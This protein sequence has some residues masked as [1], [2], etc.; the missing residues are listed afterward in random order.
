[1]L[2]PEVVN[3]G[4]DGPVI[5]VHKTWMSVRR[6]SERVTQPYIRCVSTTQAH[7]TVNVFTE[8]TTSQAVFVCTI[9]DVH[10]Y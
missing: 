9:S 3:A 7:L 10:F 5:P 4:Q 1:M 6:E 2:L 8:E